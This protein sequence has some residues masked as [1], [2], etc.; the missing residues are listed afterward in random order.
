MNTTEILSG[1]TTS[2]RAK[3]VLYPLLLIYL[4]D[5]VSCIIRWQMTGYS[6][7]IAGSCGVV[8]RARS[9]FSDGRFEA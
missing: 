3:R 9:L 8:R 5:F 4:V 1:E 6:G 7:F 2:R